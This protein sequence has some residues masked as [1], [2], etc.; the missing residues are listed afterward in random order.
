MS[1]ESRKGTVAWWE[2]Q[3]HN[4]KNDN[5]DNKNNNKDNNNCLIKGV[6]RKEGQHGVDLGM[7]IN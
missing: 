5:N 1:A 7:D 2:Q 4:N 3:Q 6:D